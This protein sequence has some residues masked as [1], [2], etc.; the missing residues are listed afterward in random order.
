MSLFRI[1]VICAFLLTLVVL[2]IGFSRRS[3]E[4]SK[5][6][7]KA[8]KV[9]EKK[10]KKKELVNQDIVSALQS[11]GFKKQ[12]SI[13]AAQKAT[14]KLGDVEIEKLIKEALKQI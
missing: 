13:I 14:K 8:E 11:L 5:Q 9:K 10:K 3:R 4:I 7:E 6:R 1:A 2:S 12:E